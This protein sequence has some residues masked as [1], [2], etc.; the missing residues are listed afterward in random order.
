MPE[1]FFLSWALSIF[2]DP[3]IITHEIDTDLGQRVP[4]IL[5]LL[6]LRSPLSSDHLGNL[7]V[8]HAR[9]LHDNGGLVMLAVQHKC[10][11]SKMG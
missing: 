4:T 1:L 9:I 10:F 8:G 5:D 3:N 11:R 7:R 2:I 6:R